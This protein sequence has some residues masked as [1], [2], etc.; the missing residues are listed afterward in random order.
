[1]PRLMWTRANVEL[2]IDKMHERFGR[3]RDWESALRPGHG[4]NA[5]YEELCSQLAAV[6][7]RGATP[8]GVDVVA[9]S[10][11][12][13]QWGDPG[14]RKGVHGGSRRVNFGT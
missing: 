11:G 14:D 7:G 10:A 6:I 2:I 1:M 5:E 9:K 8:G 4:R 12:T 13:H 3:R